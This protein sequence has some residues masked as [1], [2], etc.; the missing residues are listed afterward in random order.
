MKRAAVLSAVALIALSGCTTRV[1]GVQPAI[2]SP[3]P[4]VACLELSAGAIQGLQDGLDKKQ[5]NFTIG[6]TAAFASEQSDGWFVAGVFTGPGIEDGQA[7]VWYTIHDPTAEGENAYVSVDA[8]A[9]E[10]SWYLQPV[11]FS[12][13]L[14]GVDEVRSCLE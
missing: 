12:S 5:P 10:F 3:T 9:K 2:P 4:D 8:F 13:A 14:D 6:D 1:D 11:D 7:G